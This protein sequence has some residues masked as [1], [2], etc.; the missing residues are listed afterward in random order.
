MKRLLL[1]I[2]ALAAV[3]SFHARRAAALDVLPVSTP[4]VFNV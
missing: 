2:G 3:L 1:S 4:E